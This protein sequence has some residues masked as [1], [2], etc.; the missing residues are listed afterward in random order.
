MPRP[1]QKVVPG[2]A[3]LMA[4]CTLLAGVKAVPAHVGDEPL[5]GRLGLPAS[6]HAIPRTSN[7]KADETAS[8]SSRT[9]LPG[10]QTSRT[11]TPR[12]FGGSV[13]RI[14]TAH[15]LTMLPFP[16]E[17]PAPDARRHQAH[18]LTGSP[19]TRRFDTTRVALSGDLTPGRRACHLTPDLLGISQGRD[20]PGI[21]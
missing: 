9:D 17:P 2:A 10:C 14:R 18:R 4:A 3:L 1:K 16:A 20:S 11:G 6:G 15:H 13:C 12:K 21:L 8:R 7:V 19:R 5:P